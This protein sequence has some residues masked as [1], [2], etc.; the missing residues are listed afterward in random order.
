MHAYAGM[1]TDDLPTRVEVTVF[2]ARFVRNGGLL[3]N[4]FLQRKRDFR[5]NDFHMS[6]IA[7][8]IALIPIEPSFMVGNE[9]EVARSATSSLLLQSQKLK[10]S[11]FP[12]ESQMPS[13]PRQ[14]DARQEFR[15]LNCICDRS[16]VAAT[17]VSDYSTFFHYR[18]LG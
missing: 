15:K 8:I 4:D 17:A 2:C 14:A 12:S 13:I 1:C 6:I 5:Q 10:S 16:E 18:P 11:N 7:L 9:P 3:P